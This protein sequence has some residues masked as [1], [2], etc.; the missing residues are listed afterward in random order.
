MMP[1]RS[2][3]GKE[4]EEVACLPARGSHRDGSRMARPPDLLD[5]EATR[6]QEDEEGRRRRTTTI[7]RERGGGE[8]VRDTGRSEFI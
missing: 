4:E 2:G 5:E 6:K 3:V 8:G 7:G 1:P